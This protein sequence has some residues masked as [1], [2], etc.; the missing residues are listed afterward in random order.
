[1]DTTKREF[2]DR[3][4]CLTSKI[5]GG[6]ASNFEKYP[7]DVYGFSPIR[8]PGENYSSQA[9]YFK[10]QIENLRNEDINVTVTAIAEYDDVW[11]GWQLSLNPKIWIFYPNDLREPIHLVPDRVKSTP[12]SMSL[13]L[14][15]KPFE[16]LILSNMFTPS[17]SSLVQ[18]VE[19]LA[20]LYPTF[21]KL[22]EIGKSPK[23]H[24]IYSIIVN[25]DVPSHKLFKILIGGSPQPN[26]FGDHAAL[27][28]LQNFLK[29]DADYWDIFAKLFS[30]EFIFFQNPDGMELGTN[31]VNNKGENLFFSY[32]NELENMPMEN[33]FI[34]SYL[35]QNP[36]KLYLEMH[37]FFQDQKT[38]RPY[39]YPIDL[40]KEKREA[41]IYQ[42]L[43]K[44]LIKF[45]N[46]VKEDI[47]LNQPYFDNTL[48]YK[49]M[50]K[51]G[52]LCFQ[53][54]LH[55]RLT[56]LEISK[57]SWDLFLTLQ[58]ALRRII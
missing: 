34:W 12:W 42:K 33:Q 24:P 47:S 9:Y 37:S 15:L 7:G 50:E 35:A 8:D 28:I 58:K 22:Q 36:P 53:Y 3:K 46:G 43:A 2:R 45:S 41:K 4:I 57:I 25:P 11:K 20:S 31:M 14:S 52:T 32:C 18:K 10:F 39:I 26:E 48:C 40:L 17:L 13:N 6:N 27:Q 54:K 1:M 56:T 44:D 23:N 29:Q 5:E 21:L 19:D 49:L 16:K 30:L 51:F 55:S 38:I